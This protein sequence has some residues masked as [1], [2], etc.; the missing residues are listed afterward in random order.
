MSKKRRVQWR[1][2]KT[3]RVERDSN[4]ET[5]L[6]GIEVGGRNERKGNDFDFEALKTTK[7]KYACAYTFKRMYRISFLHNAS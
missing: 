6:G 5:T 1:E 4:R 7:T 2:K 3:E